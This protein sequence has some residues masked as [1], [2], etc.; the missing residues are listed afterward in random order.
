MMKKNGE[1]LKVAVNATALLAPLAGIGQYV[2]SLLTELDASLDLSV[3][4][5][6]GGHWSR[7]IHNQAFNESAERVKLLVRKY[8]PFFSQIYR[9]HQQQRFTVGTNKERA[10]LYH[11]PN[12]LAYK[13]D[14]PTVITAHDLSW[15]RYPEMHP[16]ERV[17]FMNRYFPDA[18]NRASQI[19]TDSDF[20]KGELIKLFD[21]RHEI[22]HTV[23]LG[24]SE[25]FHPQN[26]S[27]TFDILRSHDLLHG[28]Y[29]LALG[30]LEPRKNLE[31]AL[32]AYEML[33]LSMQAH[34]PLVLVGM[35][36]W[37]NEALE[38][39]ISL[40]LRNGKVKRLGYLVRQDLIKIVAGARLKI[41]PSLYE[42]FGLPPLEA[43]ACGVPVISS[44][45]S[46]LPE[47]LGDAGIQLPPNIHEKWT[48]TIQMLLTDD[49][50][51]A[52]LSRRS[53]EKSAQYNWKK[54]AEATKVVYEH[55]MARYG[56]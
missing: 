21:V 7:D 20:I 34:F 26:A 4:K 1:P 9:L 50:L 56:R 37:K 41:Y 48:E 2:K 29:I 43:M 39:R 44:N 35:N 54:C 36:G 31:M 28:N 15:I 3:S 30:T 45:T 13:F 19:I 25:E 18:L 24:V 51:H 42:G 5:F 11:E 16:A 17:R 6:Y 12:F 55:A 53:L 38:K 22:I 14:G 27:Q 49:V 46:S 23:P 47:I 8:V 40:M 32:T 10:D 52:N 33:P